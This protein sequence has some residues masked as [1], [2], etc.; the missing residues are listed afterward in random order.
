MFILMG[1]AGR[2]D[3]TVDLELLKNAREGNAEAQY[4]IGTIYYNQDNYTEAAIWYEKAAEQG[5]IDA[6]VFLP[7]L[8]DRY[9]EGKG[10]P[11]DNK[12]AAELYIK[13][14]RLTGYQ[15]MRL[16]G[17]YKNGDGVTQDIN[18][19]VD[20]YFHGGGYQRIA[21]IADM[22][23]EGK[24]IPQDRKKAAELYI[25]ILRAESTLTTH[26]SGKECVWLGMM[27]YDG[28]DV[29]Q[30]YIKAAE[31]FQKAINRYFPSDS[32]NYKYS[33][34]YHLG[35]MYYEGKLG[36]PDPVTG[37]AWIYLSQNPSGSSMCDNNLS[38]V[39]MS[40]VLYLLDQSK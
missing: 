13:S 26:L 17:M 35:M 7:S 20:F 28:I 10:V 18:K 15:N 3:L 11:K 4:K 38:Q 31:L 25:R 6:K 21:E 24:S 8:G 14:Y 37:C 39:Q 12:K 1:C 36:S 32:I 19:A 27:Y 23:Y 5:N 16:A 29:A 34:E 22:Y 40:R 2:A 9:F 33:A 30:D